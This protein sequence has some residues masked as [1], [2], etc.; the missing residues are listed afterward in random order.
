MQS[1]EDS[2]LI[3]GLTERTQDRPLPR[4]EPY[5]SNARRR[6]RTITIAIVLSIAI[7]VTMLWLL[8]ARPPT[9]PK[10]QPPGDDNS[11]TVYLAP[12]SA[13]VPPQPPARAAPGPRPAVPPR[14]ARPPRPRKPSAPITP[15][16]VI[17][18]EAPREVRPEPAA[19]RTPPADDMFTQLEAARKRRAEAQ[20]RDSLPAPDA[21]AQ[22]SEARDPNSIA[23]ANVAE[24]LKR[25]SG[26]NRKDS[27]GVFQVRHVG[28]RDATFVFYGWSAASRRDSSQL[29]TVEL[30][31][32]KDIQTAVVKKMIEII[33]AQTKD[34]FVWDSHRLGKQLTLSAR[35]E[36][37]A[38]LEQFM[39]REFFPD[40]AA[41]FRR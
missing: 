19:P 36:D 27:G 16:A 11:V 39:M 41:P 30:G 18:R 29:I 15:P 31:A 28:F 4:Q 32:E 7:H 23:R 37:S 38:E 13:P 24:S 20:T 10:L 6:H 12:P 40:Y 25:A 35:R 33:R 17:A 34:T 1:D 2:E 22:E 3:D 5:D 9:P 14:A 26:P 8:L 21:P